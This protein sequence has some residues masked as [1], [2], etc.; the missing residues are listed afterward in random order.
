[1]RLRRQV[2]EVDLI[3]QPLH[4]EVD[5]RAL[6]GHLG[7]P[8]RNFGMGGFGVYQAY[9]RMIREEQTASSVEYL[10]FYIW[11][12]DHVRSLLRCRHAATDSSP[13]RRQRSVAPASD[14]L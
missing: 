7:E 14:S 11:G 6:A 10:I 5:R 2:F 4:V 13:G 1:M 12:D 9:R 8:I 3:R